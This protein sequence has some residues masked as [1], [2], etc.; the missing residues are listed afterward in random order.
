MDGTA[1]QVLREIRANWMRR[2]GVPDISTA[3]SF[4]TFSLVS[5]LAAVAVT[6]LLVIMLRW[7]TGFVPALIL[8][9][10]SVFQVRE[11]FRF[12]FLDD[13][14][15]AQAY[16]LVIRVLVWMVLARLAVVLL[17][18]VLSC[19][20]L[21]PDRLV[22]IDYVLFYSRVH[23]VP[24]RRITRLSLQGTIVHRLF[25]LGCVSIVTELAGPLHVGPIPRVSQF[26]AQAA[27]AIE[28]S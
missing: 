6:V 13:E 21:L 20:L 23:H 4:T 11:I 9:W 19:I 26:I 5:A 25:D 12:E 15:V 2:V 7:T 17:R 3:R 27:S 18:Q 10:F 8:R 28:R 22:V 1:R 24:Y 16:E 14:S